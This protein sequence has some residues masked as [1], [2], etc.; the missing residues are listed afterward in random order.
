M[1]LFYLSRRNNGF[2]QVRFVDQ[3]TG[4]MSIAK[5]THEKDR[6]AACEVVYRW[7]QSGVPQNRINAAKPNMQHLSINEKVFNDSAK[8]FV[9]RLTDSNA[10]CL[11]N[12]LAGRLKKYSELPEKKEV[13]V[14]SSVSDHPVCSWLT[15]FWTPE[16]SKYIISRRAHGFNITDRHCY[17]M[18]GLI[19]RY[20]Q[21]YF[22]D[23]T[24]IGDIDE[25]VLEDFF[26]NLR[27]ERALSGATVN[28]A[29]NSG[30]VACKCAFEHKLI[31][32]NPFMTV[33]RFSVDQ[34][35][36]GI[37]EDSEVSAFFRLRW[38][39]NRK[40]LVN[41]LAA[42]SGLR[43]GEISGL[44]VCDIDENAIH[45]RHSWNTVDGLK[46]TKNNHERTVPVMP[47]ICQ[48]LLAQARSS[49]VYSD[50]SFV[51]YS[52]KNKQQKPLD[53]GLYDEWFAESLNMIGISDIQKRERNLVFHGWRHFY[54]KQMAQRVKLEQA[55]QALGHLTQSM[56]LHYA[57][58]RT[59]QDFE[60][61]TNAMNDSYAN[62]LSFPAVDDNPGVAKEVST[63]NYSLLVYGVSGCTLSI[64]VKRGSND[65]RKKSDRAYW[66]AFAGKPVFRSFECFRSG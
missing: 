51:F 40:K 19:K 38:K 7:L 55:Q 54:A 1:R 10:E 13:K 47:E 37:L 15:D 33:D 12:A 25:E 23:N 57:D 21:P 30:A 58:H 42:F 9:D 53:P 63:V 11:F 20:W 39:D 2:Y 60:T 44:R 18:R 62:I 5:S 35:K 31:K 52:Q 14:T 8:Q 59:K 27:V 48:E 50:T 4:V 46:K 36:R 16:K 6:Q 45:I 65:R 66:F 56:T 3:Q 41:I 64:Q 17:E 24:L 49:P 22:G 32:Q 43:A 29:I 61:L 26:L 28:K 34:E